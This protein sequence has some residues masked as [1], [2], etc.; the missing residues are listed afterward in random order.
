M[1]VIFK[2]KMGLTP[3]YL[4]GG[5][6]LV[7]GKRRAPVLKEEQGKLGDK[8]DKNENSKKINCVQES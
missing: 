6:R 1:C 8:T 7:G 2:M 4:V 5:G 3:E